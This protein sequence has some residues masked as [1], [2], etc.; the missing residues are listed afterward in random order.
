MSTGQ[1][2]RVDPKKWAGV[3][4]YE[5]ETQKFQG[6]P[7]VCYYI[8]YYAG[9]KRRM[10][11]VGWKSEGYGPEVAAELRG[12]RVRQN[13]HGNEVKTSKEIRLEKAKKEQTIDE[14]A[15]LYFEA[16]ADEKWRRIDRNRYQKDVSPYVGRKRVSDISQ[17]DIDRIQKELVG[18]QPATVW[19]VL[20]ILR[21]LINY[22]VSKKVSPPLAFSIIMPDVDNERT[23]YL[24][25]DE[26][27]RF[28][29]VLSTWKNQE[30]VRMLQLAMF[31]GMR[32]G[33]VFRL[34][35]AHL[36]F[37]F[38]LI[39]LNKPKGGRT[40][41]IPMNPIARDMLK[42]QLNWKQEQGTTS[43]YVFP[44]KFDGERTDCSAVDNI[45]KAAKLPKQFRIFHGL[46]HH[47]AVILA[48]SGQFT[49]DLI[50]ELLTHKD[51]KTTKKY[52]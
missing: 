41:T 10:D 37:H 35:E 1:R 22:G 47:F 48:N 25:P 2:R 17:G 29:K 21:R 50:A 13:R 33:E 49:L 51:V 8:S 43:S 36:D 19:A 27:K 5:S 52:S 15:K 28:R 11:K 12:E 40:A 3:Y 18:K 46:R 44:G 4:Y 16:K 38:G 20:E 31:T 6:K 9:P 30:A 42:S 24:N 34:E 45:K 32:R 39:T 14:I 7:D 26:L 23:E